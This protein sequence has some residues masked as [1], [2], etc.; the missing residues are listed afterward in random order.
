[1][2]CAASRIPP[3]IV[4]IIQFLTCICIS[5]YTEHQDHEAYTSILTISL[6]NRFND[7]VAKK[8]RPPAACVAT[9]LVFVSG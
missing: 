6:R 3:C 4:H 5:V 1:M 2:E 9:L 8:L 7:L